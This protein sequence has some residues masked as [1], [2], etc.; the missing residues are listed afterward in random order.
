MAADIVH[1]IDGQAAENNCASGTARGITNHPIS[2]WEKCTVSSHCRD[3]TQLVR[4]LPTLSVWLSLEIIRPGRRQIQYPLYPSDGD[5]SVKLIR[6]LFVNS[7]IL[8]HQS[9]ARL[10]REAAEQDEHW[11]PITL[12]SVLSFRSRIA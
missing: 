8:G 6:A 5:P 11:S 1:L 4:P 10:V 2:V 9:V 7:G 3:D 12:I